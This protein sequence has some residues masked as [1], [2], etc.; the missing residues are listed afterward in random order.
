MTY[1]DI[2]KHH[3]L[4]RQQINPRYSLRAF[5]KSLEI[6]ASKMSEIIS[7]KKCLSYQRAQKL[8]QSLKLN[9]K[10]YEL[11]IL[12]VELEQSS[13][14][15]NQHL[16]KQRIQKL[17]SQI[18]SEKTMQKNAW[19]FGAIACLEKHDLNT[20][21]LKTISELTDLQIENAKRYKH[22]LQKLHP[23][24]T[25]LSYEP[26]SLIKKIQES[27]ISNC[28]TSSLNA[29]FVFLSKKD[30]LQ[31]EQKIKKLLLTIKSKTQKPNPKN[32]C[33]AHWGIIRLTE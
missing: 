13:K 2:L 7:G 12:S 16:A 17:T 29:D 4:K 9:I 30:A 5:S 31:L 27:Q 20:K 22:R 14:E 8:A 15:I 6:S 18:N 23:E 32:L 26:S 19:Y 21:E 3:L 10:E 28:E 1:R 25:E 11:F 24:K 33:M